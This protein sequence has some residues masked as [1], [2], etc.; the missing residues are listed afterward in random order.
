[1]SEK[2]KDYEVGYGRPP[3]TSRFKPGQSGNPSGRRSGKRKNEGIVCASPLH[4]T[5]KALSKRAERLVA[6]VE[7]GKRQLVPTRDAVLGALAVTALKGGVLAQRT[8]IQLM[9]AEDD[10]LHHRRSESMAFWRKHVLAARRQIDDARRRGASPPHIIPHPDDIIFDYETMTLKI[11]GP[12]SEEEA[13]LCATIRSTAMLCF[14]LSV[15]Y[16]EDNHFDALELGK[17]R[18][19]YWLIHHIALLEK[20]PPR[21]R[22]ITDH[23]NAELTMRLGSRQRWERH[24]RTE[25]RALGLP[26][27]P[28]RRPWKAWTLSNLLDDRKVE[29]FCGS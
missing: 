1:M 17:S 15:F 11:V 9:Q 3:K 7:D 6:I 5:N 27:I 12:A 26:F 29:N 13:A 19:G 10:R 23:E 14:E 21:M 25:C 16:G 4:P 24:L 18:I 2:D 8:L 20:L 22:K 28:Y